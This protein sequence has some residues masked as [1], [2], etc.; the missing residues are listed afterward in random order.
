MGEEALLDRGRGDFFPPPPSPT[1]NPYRVVYARVCKNNPEQTRQPTNP[2]GVVDYFD[3][4]TLFLSTP[5]FSSPYSLFLP[6]L[7][8]TSL[9]QGTYSFSPY[10]LLLPSLLLKNML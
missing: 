10:Y 9:L 4:S 7:P 3:C 8:L 1:T 2:D 6:S 5:Y